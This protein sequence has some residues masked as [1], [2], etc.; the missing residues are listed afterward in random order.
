MPY[1]CLLGEVEHAAKYDELCSS[2]VGCLCRPRGIA[3]AWSNFAYGPHWLFDRSDAH[4]RCRDRYFRSLDRYRRHRHR[5]FGSFASF[6]RHDGPSRSW[7]DCYPARRN[8]VIISVEA[9][10]QRLIPRLAL[11][12]LERLLHGKHIA[13]GDQSVRAY[14]SEAWRQILGTPQFRRTS[15]SDRVGSSISGPV[16]HGWM[17]CVTGAERRYGK[18]CLL[19]NGSS[20]RAHGSK[21]LV[22]IR[23]DIRR[24]IANGRMVLVGRL[25]GIVTVVCVSAFTVIPSSTMDATSWP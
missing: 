25:G 7:G 17:A 9:W 4:G 12:P 21:D 14:F 20:F 18:L 19:R 24:T 6:Y 11:G 10:S 2:C 15:G 1:L 3:W 16:R 8:V 23:I 13:A 22:P 5:R